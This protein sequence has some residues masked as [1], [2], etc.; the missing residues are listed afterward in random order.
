MIPLV[1]IAAAFFLKCSRMRKESSLEHVLMTMCGSVIRRIMVTSI[2]TGQP[3]PRRTPKPSVLLSRSVLGNGSMRRRSQ[4]IRH[5]SS[6]S[7]RRVQTLFSLSRKTP[8]KQALAEFSVWFRFD[9]LRSQI[10][11][12]ANDAQFKTGPDEH[13][14]HKVTQ[15][16]KTL[17]YG[18]W[19]HANTFNGQIVFIFVATHTKSA[20]KTKDFENSV[21]ACVQDYV[22]VSK[23]RERITE[24]LTSIVGRLWREI[25]IGRLSLLSHVPFLLMG[26]EAVYKY[27]T[28]SKSR[29]PSKKG[30]SDWPPKS[31][32]C[33]IDRGSSARI[34]GDTFYKLIV[35]MKS[36]YK[37]E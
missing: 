18:K 3:I 30:Q 9:C 13:T 37:D 11:H 16:L 33:Y 12:L 32:F 36:K 20:I 5:S 4:I 1:P 6:L 10:Y 25:R 7:K 34:W 35:L 2:S 19:H 27:L 21:R 29:P 14:T 31:Y 15:A 8:L 17:A 28:R 22:K 26:F 23:R 24:I